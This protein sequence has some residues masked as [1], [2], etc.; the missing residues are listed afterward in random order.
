MC[1]V[2]SR[3][4][5]YKSL[6][7]PTNLWQGRIIACNAGGGCSVRCVSSHICTLCCLSV[8]QVIDLSLQWSIPSQKILWELVHHQYQTYTRQTSATSDA[9]GRRWQSDETALFS[10][11]DPPIRSSLSQF[12]I[13]VLDI[14]A[15]KPQVLVVPLRAGWSCDGCCVIC[16]VVLCCVVLCCVVL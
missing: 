4:P 10:Y 7:R 2:N 12:I 8:L 15:F 3:I 16:C 5:R 9:D 6:Q 13:N 1:G 11:G 14:P